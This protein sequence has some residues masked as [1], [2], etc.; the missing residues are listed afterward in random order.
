[1]Q[2]FEKA[3]DYQAFA[4]VLQQPEVRHSCLTAIAVAG[5]GAV[6]VMHGV[7]DLRATDF[8]NAALAVRA[9]LAGGALPVGRP[10]E[11]SFAFPTDE[12]RVYSGFPTHIIVFRR[13]ARFS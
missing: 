6:D 1:M 9:T 2:V 11:G 10:P 4:R 12:N 7:H 13:A 5:Y 8:A 3:G